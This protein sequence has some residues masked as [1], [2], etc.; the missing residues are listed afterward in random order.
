[1]KNSNRHTAIV[2][3]ILLTV[4]ASLLASSTI[5]FAQQSGMSYHFSTPIKEP[6]L[7]DNTPAAG[8]VLTS[9]PSQIKLDVDFYVGPGDQ[10]SMLKDGK[11][12]GMGVTVV[13]SD[14]RSVTRSVDP[15]A[16]NGL[17]TLNYELCADDGECHPGQYQFAIQK[18]GNIADGQATDR[19]FSPPKDVPQLTAHTPLHGAVLA[20]APINVVVDFNYDRG[21]G[22]K[23]AILKDGKDYG[24][25]DS[26]IDGL[27]N[28]H[29]RRNM[30]SDAPDG[31]Y[32][33]K[34]TSCQ[35]NG[36]FNGSCNDGTFQF[37]IDRSKAST[38]TDLRGQ[39]AVTITMKN[40]SFDPMY[41]MV[42]KGT[43]VTWKNEDDVIHY[44]NTDQH[45]EHS[46]YPPMNSPQ[47]L[48]KGDTFTLTFDRPGL[49]PYHCSAHMHMNNMTGTLLVK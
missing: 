46:Y 28:L 20:D 21:P 37:A 32:T 17:Y 45:P 34:Y 9:V 44:V 8:A 35:L 11:E 26:T 49:Y 19:R 43:T 10:I 39:K 33:V 22:S 31:I 1:M 15:Y 16:P 27:S 14:K 13:S 5:S 30:T 25:G 41:V 36:T 3:S 48:A 12:Y 29:I 47:P 18:A 40:I 23:I 2:L 42:S 4:G 7:K 6:H 38:F 24:I